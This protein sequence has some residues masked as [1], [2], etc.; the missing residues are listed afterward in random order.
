MLVVGVPGFTVT[1]TVAMP[2]SAVPAALTTLSHRP[3]WKWSCPTNPAGGRIDDGAIGLHLDRPVP[4]RAMLPHNRLIARVGSGFWSLAVTAIV[5]GVSRVV[6][7]ES[8]TAICARLT[9]GW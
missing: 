4:R 7:T 3:Y 6:V 1:M 9:T 8:S 5:T 2:Q